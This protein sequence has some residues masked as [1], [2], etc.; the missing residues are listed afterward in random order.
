M[1]GWSTCAPS[2]GCLSSSTLYLTLSTVCCGGHAPHGLV[3]EPL[4]GG[5]HWLKQRRHY[6]MTDKPE[7]NRAP[8]TSCEKCGRQDEVIEYDDAAGARVVR[9]VSM[10]AMS[11]AGV[12]WSDGFDRMD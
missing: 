7:E 8:C 10:L 4:R 6:T 1:T 5:D 9:R 3:P 2:F 12:K 11:A